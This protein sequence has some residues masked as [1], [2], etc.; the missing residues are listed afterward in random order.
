MLSGVTSSRSGSFSDTI[1]TITTLLAT[2]HDGLG[3]L[4]AVTEACATALAADATG[5]LILDPR[6]DVELLAASDERA[7]FVELLQS[8]VLQGPCLDCIHANTIVGSAD[9]VEDE[10]WPLFAA[11]SAAQGFRAVHA[12]PLRLVDKAVGSVNVLFAVPTVLSDAELRAGQAL[13]DLAVLGLTQERDERRIERLAER[14]VAALND[15]VHVSQAVGILAVAAD[16]DPDSARAYLA[17]YSVRTGRGIREVAQAL[18]D[19][20]L[21]VSDLLPTG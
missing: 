20:E 12:F 2:Q 21:S 11:A 13:A 9:L 10:R 7:R 6:G 4:R 3:I 14:T 18:T 19:G 5:V 17:A 8:H 15:R 1:A 16:T